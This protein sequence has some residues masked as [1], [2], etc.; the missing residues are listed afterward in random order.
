MTR[1]SVGPVI[2]RVTESQARVL[3]EFDQ[4]ADIPIVVSSSGNDDQRFSVPVVANTPTVFEVKNLVVGR[5]YRLH[6]LVDNGRSRG[7]TI[8]PVGA[9][10]MRFATVSCYKLTQN[11]ESSAWDELA[12][13]AMR[14]DV[15]VVL[16]TGDQVY[17]DDV[18]EFWTAYLKK[19]PGRL[20][21]SFTPSICESYRGLYRAAWNHLPMQSV[22]R[23]ASN[24]MLWDDHE[25]TDD[26]G[27]KQNFA[28]PNSTEHMVARCA[29]Q[30]YREYQRQL[31]DD[32]AVKKPITVEGHEGHLQVWEHTAA[33]FVD[34]RGGRAFQMYDRRSTNPGVPD[35]YLGTTQWQAILDALSPSSGP[36]ESIEKLLVVCPV[37]L[38]FFPPAIAR[39]VVVRAIADDIRGHWCHTPYQEEQHRLLSAL[40]N[41]Q[42]GRL[43][44]EVLLLGGDVH[45]GC[46]MS[47]FHQRDGETPIFRQIVSS[48]VH[49]KTESERLIE[50]LI[51]PQLKHPNAER[52]TRP[53]GFHWKA[54]NVTVKRNFGEI[55]TTRGEA[56]SAGLVKTG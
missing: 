28:D 38:V 39:D 12:E 15:D 49:R 34:V 52:T 14:G 3:V 53:Q 42:A 48:P 1:I 17:G 4:T 22:L 19:V 47:V 51:V 29:W 44:R 55:V 24:L 33:L 54:S 8:R 50:T 56:I 25:V 20:R 35:P 21:E 18:F 10:A 7:A 31:W 36:L 41:W 2:G 9:N 13:R 40:R 27:D 5:S 11:L 46:E 26:W 45:F 6:C 16:H 23:N 37:P 32:D 30:V 43:G